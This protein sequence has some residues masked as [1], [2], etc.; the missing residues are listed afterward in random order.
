MAGMDWLADILIALLALAGTLGG[1]Y[2]AN[3]RSSALIAY[4]IQQLEQKVDEHNSVIERTYAL[5]Q[6]SELLEE[7][8]KVANHR[9]D[10]LEK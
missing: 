6:R 9:I 4:R 7:R 2:L 8:I 10:D 5:E 3:R 1:A